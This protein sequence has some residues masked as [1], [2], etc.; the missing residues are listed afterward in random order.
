MRKATLKNKSGM[1]WLGAA[2]LAATL[3]MFGCSSNQYAGNGQ[4][5]SITPTMDTVNHSMTYGSS[6]GTEGTP[7]PMAS[8]YSS[9]AAPRVNVDALAVLAADRGF[10]GYV[11]GP[12]NPGG[13]QQGVAVASGQF[14]SPANAVL[15][16]STVNSSINSQPVPAITGGDIGLTGGA[17]A[18]ASPIPTL[19]GGATTTGTTAST[20]MTPTSSAATS[21]LTA[22][23]GSPTVAGSA[24]FSP[25]LM[26]STP[27]PQATGTTGPT[28]RTV[29]A[30]GTVVT[31][32]TATPGR[33]AARTTPAVRMTTGTATA[34]VSSGIQLQTTQ[35]GG[36]VMTNVSAPAVKGTSGK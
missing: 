35:S 4:P 26:N 13:A 7:P 19:T 11:L 22:S 16:Q 14:E 15:P 36:I 28:L 8:S 17:V 30:T 18:A 2:S 25:V 1:G 20:T 5:T 23:T 21:A 33:T 6:S 27:A 29:V 10:R 34:R 9:P 24:A 12:S 32:N 3:A 31:G